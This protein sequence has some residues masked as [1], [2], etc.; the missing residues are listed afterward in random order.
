MTTDRETDPDRDFI[1]GLAKGLTVIECFEA[2]R[3]RLTIADVARTTGISRA[4]ARRCLL[5]LE[6]LRYAEFDGK[7]FRLTPRV[8]RLGY[9]Y[10]SA[11]ALPQILQPYL[12]RLSEMTKES[13]SASILDSRE[14]VYIARSAQKRIMS[15]G[16]NIGTRLPAYC[17][18]MGRVLLA[19]LPPDEARRRILAS[20]RHKLTTGTLV[21]MRDLV[22]SVARAREKGFAIVD[23][24]LEIGLASISVP[25]YNS[26]GTCVAAV[27]IS[28]QSQRLS[29]R[30]LEAQFL[31]HLVALQRAVRPLIA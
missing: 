22:L 25:V 12:E 29:A 19:S 15:V 5:T 24:E 26:A 21:A 20:E 6:R 10:L 31:P 16:L 1:A 23:Q 14:V 4:A 7:F 18:S 30:D 27:N 13:C 3:E 9:A 2:G 8:L 17:T 11:T 28:A